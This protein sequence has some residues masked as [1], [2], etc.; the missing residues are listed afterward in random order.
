MTRASASITASAS[1]LCS[2]RHQPVHYD[3]AMMQSVSIHDA[4][5]ARRRIRYMYMVMALTGPEDGSAP[6]RAVRPVQSTSHGRGSCCSFLLRRKSRRY[7]QSYL[8]NDGSRQVPRVTM[9]SISKISSLLEH[10]QYYL[11]PF[12][13]LITHCLPPSP[14]PTPS[15][16]PSPTWRTFAGNWPTPPPPPHP[17][18]PR[19]RRRP[20]PP[21]PSPA[22]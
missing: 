9:E 15:P 4:S 12:L 22:S 5:Q 16:T 8:P 20:P 19:R 13:T 2:A 18:S 6:H 17:P 1:D 3:H 10:G 11:C 7:V 21:P 14:T